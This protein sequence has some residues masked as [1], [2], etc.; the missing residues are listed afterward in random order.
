MGE[1]FG[2]GNVEGA[3]DMYEL[4]HYIDEGSICGGLQ[5]AIRDRTGHICEGAAGASQAGQAGLRDEDPQE[6][7]HPGE[8]PGEEHHERKGNLGLT[9][10][11]LPRSPQGVLPRQ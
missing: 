6:K 2:M 8:E 11:P 4:I 7:V 3:V 10:P 5:P 9:R 1:G